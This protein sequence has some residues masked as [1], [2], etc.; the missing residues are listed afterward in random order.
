[1]LSTSSAKVAM[2]CWV[3]CISV[4]GVDVVG[5]VRSFPAITSIRP[6]VGVQVNLLVVVK[7]RTMFPMLTSTANRTSPF[8]TINAGTDFHFTY[9]RESDGWV[10]SKVRILA[11]YSCLWVDS[12][13]DTEFEFEWQIIPNLV[14]SSSMWFNHQSDNN[15]A[16]DALRYVLYGI[17]L[18]TLY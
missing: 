5:R 13:S 15:T 17:F 14:S 7:R 8:H 1:M 16:R 9:N 10:E 3:K 2:S 6:K 4:N 12:D 11:R 18:Y